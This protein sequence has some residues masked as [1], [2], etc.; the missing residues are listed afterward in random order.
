MSA[1]AQNPFAGDPDCHEIWEILMR[2]DF[3]AFVAADWSR[4]EPD[5]LAE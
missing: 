2:R 3:E 5:F 4:A 1:A